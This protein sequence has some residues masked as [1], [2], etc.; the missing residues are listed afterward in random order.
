LD[1]MWVMEEDKSFWEIQSWKDNGWNRIVAKLNIEWH[2]VGQDEKSRII[3]LG[4]V[5]G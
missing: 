3:K 2:L 1:E 4:K 5:L